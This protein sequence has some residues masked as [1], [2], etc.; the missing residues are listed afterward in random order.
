M[1]IKEEKELKIK[2]SGDNM[3]NFKSAIKKITEETNT[4]GFSKSKLN[5]DEIKVIQELNSKIN[6]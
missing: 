3:D 4:A 6:Q 1:T 2:L 5:G